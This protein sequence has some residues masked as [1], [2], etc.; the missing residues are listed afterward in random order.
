[1]ESAT[2]KGIY[3]CKN[4]V[5][6]MHTQET[7]RQNVWE[8]KGYLVSYLPDLKLADSLVFNGVANL[9]WMFNVGL[10]LLSFTITYY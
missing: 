8:I 1:M 9:S 7:L 4:N 3:S 6:L 10:L 5:I 2:N